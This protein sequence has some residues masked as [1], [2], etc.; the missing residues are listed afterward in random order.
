MEEIYGSG[1]ERTTFKSYEIVV[2]LFRSM[3]DEKPILI[4]SGVQD[5]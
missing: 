5:L 4:E 1:I 2:Q 3:I